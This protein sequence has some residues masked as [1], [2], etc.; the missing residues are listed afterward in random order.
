MIFLYFA[1]FRFASRSCSGAGGGLNQSI[2]KD[3]QLKEGQK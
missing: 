3:I 1:T 2:G